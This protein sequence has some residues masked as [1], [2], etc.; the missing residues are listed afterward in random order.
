[1]D[2]NNEMVNGKKS[3]EILEINIIQQNP[4]DHWGSSGSKHHVGGGIHILG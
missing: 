2:N 3:E 1:M 4:P